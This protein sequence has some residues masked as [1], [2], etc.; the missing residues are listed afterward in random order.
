MTGM[1]STL[2]TDFEANQ[3]P[4]LAQKASITISSLFGTCALVPAAGAAPKHRRDAALACR[5][6]RAA[7]SSF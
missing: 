7:S 3:E 2:Q 5:L 6:H 1:M 4:G